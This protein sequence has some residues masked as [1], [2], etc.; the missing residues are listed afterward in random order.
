LSDSSETASVCNTARC[1]STF[2]LLTAIIT[3]IIST[4]RC[5]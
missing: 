1:I 3:V 4:C 2:Y 5:C